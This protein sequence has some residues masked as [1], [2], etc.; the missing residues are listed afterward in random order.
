MVLLYFSDV[1]Q[2]KIVD[3][4]SGDGL[5]LNYE[6]KMQLETIENEFDGLEV[7]YA[8]HAFDSLWISLNF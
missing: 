6:N 3:H 5:Q 1:V 2:W 7:V 4:Y 8:V